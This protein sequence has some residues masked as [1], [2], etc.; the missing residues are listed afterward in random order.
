MMFEIRLYKFNMKLFTEN[1][2]TKKNNYKYISRTRNVQ[3]AIIRK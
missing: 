1:K 3:Y 2:K